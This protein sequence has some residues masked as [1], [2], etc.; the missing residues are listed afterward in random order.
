M[1]PAQGHVPKFSISYLDTHP[2]L[3]QHVPRC[4]Q[5]S[6]IAAMK[7]SVHHRMTSAPSA[8]F[9]SLSDSWYKSRHEK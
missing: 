5:N 1:R 9:L 2:L 3:S 7:V 6:I 8:G 4:L